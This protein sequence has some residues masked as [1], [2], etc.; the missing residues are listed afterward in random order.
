MENEKV[1]HKDVA[2]KLL[3]SSLTK[4]AHRW[5]KGLLNNHIASYEDF[6]K[7]FKNIWTMQ[8]DNGI[9]VARFN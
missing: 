2:M 5:F 1:E 3:P 8:K 7:L 9:I 6:P 4:D